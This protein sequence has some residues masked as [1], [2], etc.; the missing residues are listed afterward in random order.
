MGNGKFSKHLFLEVPFLPFTKQTELCPFKKEMYSVFSYTEWN[1]IILLQI[2]NLIT[3]FLWKHIFWKQNHFY[4]V[5]CS[6]ETEPL[7]MEDILI[8]EIS[9]NPQN[10]NQF[11]GN[12]SNCKKKSYR[13]HF[14]LIQ[15]F[16]RS[17]EGGVREDLHQEQGK[18]ERST[19]GSVVPLDSATWGGDLTLLHV[20]A[21][22][23]SEHA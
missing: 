2:M 13:I 21:D 12:L 5:S 9:M 16:C 10:A 20:W 14:I 3:T 18:A 7:W 11:N 15:V 8:K 22:P 23:V 19:L 1:T 4:W 6:S 17:G